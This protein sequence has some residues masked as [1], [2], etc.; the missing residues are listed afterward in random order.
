MNFTLDLGIKKDTII[1]TVQDCKIEKWYVK[2]IRIDLV[3]TQNVLK[4]DI[5]HAIF[6]DCEKYNDGVNSC[7]RT[8]RLSHCFL[9]KEDLIK[10][11]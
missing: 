8:F 10:Q 2:M 5:S 11:L 3:N 6:L 7:E 4:R 9:T 1:Y